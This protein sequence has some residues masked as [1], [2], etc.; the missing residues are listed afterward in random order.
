LS[1]IKTDGGKTGWENFSC[2]P[3]LANS[4]GVKIS[5]DGS[6]LIGNFRYYANGRKGDTTTKLISNYTCNDP[7]FK[8]ERKGG[9]KTGGA[10]KYCSEQMPIKYECKNETIKKVQACLGLVTDGK[11]G[12]KTKQALIDIGQNGDQIDSGTIIAACKET[13]PTTQSKPIFEPDDTEELSATD[14]LN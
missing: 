6:Y 1:K 9:V 2:V 7:E 12:P 11:F 5:S 10:Y 14:I 4:K 8:T 3:N 13:K